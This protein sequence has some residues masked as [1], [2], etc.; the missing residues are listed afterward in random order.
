MKRDTPMSL[1][2]QILRRRVLEEMRKP[3]RDGRPRFASDAQLAQVLHVDPSHISH[4]LRSGK[5]GVSWALV[6]QLATVFDLQIWQLFYT[7][8]PYQ[9]RTK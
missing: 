2:L 3:G 9:W 5:R 1:S 8:A 6:D 4:F 7:D